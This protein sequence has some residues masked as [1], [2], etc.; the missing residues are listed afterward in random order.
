MNEMIERVAQAIGAAHE[1]D[2][3]I[4]VALEELARAAIAAMREP[5]EAMV[6]AGWPRAARIWRQEMLQATWREMIDASLVD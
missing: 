2:A 5:T 4:L 1:R 6:D 3:P